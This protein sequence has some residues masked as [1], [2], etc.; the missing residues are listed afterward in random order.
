MATEKMTLVAVAMVL[1]V[2]T[3]SAARETGAFCVPVRTLKNYEHLS[4]DILNPAVLHL[5]D[6]DH[7]VPSKGALFGCPTSTVVVIG[8]A[9]L[10]SCFVPSRVCSQ[11]PAKVCTICSF[12]V[13][14]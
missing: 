14:R 12:I 9:L 3:A 5:V 6:T 2:A 7:A 13:K 8:T 11:L 4:L 10:V 1:L